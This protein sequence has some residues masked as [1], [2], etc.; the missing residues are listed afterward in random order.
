M[1]CGLDRIDCCV[2][3][4]VEKVESRLFMYEL[5][6]SSLAF[7]GGEVTSGGNEVRERPA[8]VAEAGSLLGD[9]TSAAMFVCLC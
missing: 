1:D 2:F 7:E 5:A 6:R 4:C 3:E 9:K 8:W